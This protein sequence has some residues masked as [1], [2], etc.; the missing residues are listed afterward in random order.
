MR[1][2]R[3]ERSLFELN[4]GERIKGIRK[5]NN[6]SQEQFSELFHVTR[7]TI[8]NWENGKSLP[9]LEMIV[10]ISDYFD[11]SI[12]D[13][14]KN[15]PSLVKK[16]DSEKSKKK[17]LLITLGILII[18][19]TSIIFFSVNHFKKMNQFSF[20]MNQ[21]KSIETKANSSEK[22]DIETGYFNLLRSGKVKIDI[23]GD[24]DSGD[25]SVHLIDTKKKKEV[26]QITGDQIKDSETLLLEKS[27]Y[28][29]Q[30]KANNYKE[31]M[32]TYTYQINVDNY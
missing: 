14:L 24:I 20:N 6:L 30:V 1:V 16:I 18:L 13:L 10:Q 32:V 9:D 2:F 26:Y 12:D 4:I 27:S 3:Y 11:V 5:E 31:K 7:Q 28:K 29:I 22:I 19:A 17:M 23:N 25:L 15:N 8:S 21:E